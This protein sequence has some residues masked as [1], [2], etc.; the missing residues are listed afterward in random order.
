MINR[1]LVL[2]IGLL[3]TGAVVSQATV[4]PAR[5]SRLAEETTSAATVLKGSDTKVGDGFGESVA[6]SANTVVI[7]APGHDAGRAYV[8][9][10]NAAGWQQDA[11]LGASGTARTAFGTSV[12]ISGGTIVVGAPDAPGGGRAYV[13]AKVGE[14]WRLSAELHGAD[15]RAGDY[16]GL[17]VALSGMNIVVGAPHHGA[18]TGRAYMFTKEPSGWRQTAELAGTDSGTNDVFATAVAISGPTVVVGALG[19]AGEAGRAYAFSLTGGG[20]RQ[21]AELDGSDTVGGDAFGASVA[22][23]GTTVV[24]GS[25]GHARGGWPKLFVHRSPRRALAPGGRVGGRRP[26]RCLRASGG[27]FWRRRRRRLGGPRLRDSPRLPLQARTIA[28]APVR[29]RWTIGHCR[30][31]ELWHLGS[32]FGNDPRRRLLWR[33]LAAPAVWTSSRYEVETTRGEQATLANAPA[34]PRSSSRP[35]RQASQ[36]HR[37]ATRTADAYPLGSQAGQP[38]RPSLT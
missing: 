37:P 38:P 16:F 19:H 1:G 32:D 17:S 24:V 4:K 33:R 27:A 21:T 6:V 12:A 3:A 29:H 14:A 10:D 22:V 28:V 11:E 23:S 15:T 36:A 25:F 7:G 20:W 2:L 31:R 35:C 9:A 8:F 26:L 13:F 30:Q 34:T 18:L 5:S